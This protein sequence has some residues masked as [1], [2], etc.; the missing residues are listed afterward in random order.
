MFDATANLQIDNGRQSM[1]SWAGHARRGLGIQA[2]VMGAIIRVR[3][4]VLLNLAL[5]LS[6]GASLAG[7]GVA[8]YA[9]QHAG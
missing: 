9:L 2:T 6:I 7:F 1:A 8:L 3:P 5:A 4:M